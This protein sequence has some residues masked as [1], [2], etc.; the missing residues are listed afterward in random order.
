MKSGKELQ[1]SDRTIYNVCR[2]TRQDTY[3]KRNFTLIGFTKNTSITTGQMRVT[4]VSSQFLPTVSNPT[5]LLGFQVSLVSQE[6]CP[7]TWT[8][9]SNQGIISSTDEQVWIG[10]N[11]SLLPSGWD[12]SVHHILHP[13]CHGGNQLHFF[14]SRHRAKNA[15]D[16]DF[17]H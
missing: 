13:Y 12:L 2:P 14:C 16:T 1:W 4:L 11:A 9:K 5:Y 7:E 6:F 3:Q 15:L 17:S 10:S 8:I